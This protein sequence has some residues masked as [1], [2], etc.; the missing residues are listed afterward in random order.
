MVDL[1][2]WDVITHP[3]RVKT[4]DDYVAD[5]DRCEQYREITQAQHFAVRKLLVWNKKKGGIRG[6]SLVADYPPLLLKKGDRLEPWSGC[7]DV[8]SFARIAASQFPT[9]VLFWRASLEGMAHHRNPLYDPALGLTPSETS[10]LDW[11]HTLSLGCFQTYCSFALDCLFKADSWGSKETTQAVCLERNINS[12]AVDVVS[13]VKEQNKAGR[14]L[15]EPAIKTELF[16]K[17][18]KPQFKF[19]G[20]ET[21]AILE[22]I[23]RQL[24]PR[25]ARL[26]PGTDPASPR[27][28]TLIDG[29]RALL[30]MLT[31][32][33][34]CPKG[35]T[36][37]QTQSF[38]RSAKTYLRMLMVLKIKFK[39]KDHMLLEM[40][41][42]VPFQ[43]SPS[44]YG[45]WQDE[46]LNR[47]LRDVAEGA[48]GAVH[49]R[50]VLIEFPRA[51]DNVRLAQ[52]AKRRRTD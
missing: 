1:E 15:T 11:L 52:Q 12:F 28:Q 48:H 31:I 8:A 18:S 13:W 32:I 47:L 22:F 6:L 2:S 16:G 44:L 7:T 49:A 5:C 20:G 10:A 40:S 23:V 9:R 25:F 45:C 29:G 34:S 35:C 30:D 43:G 19:K 14:T 17:P 21:N 41:T 24:G 27:G 46:S 33:R 50:R 26:P 3:F 39:P 4:W 38:Y 42:R 36:A 51:H 37:A